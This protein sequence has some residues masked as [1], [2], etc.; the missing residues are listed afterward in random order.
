MSE[1]TLPYQPDGGRESPP[2]N[3]AMSSSARTNRDTPAGTDP[4]RTSTPSTGSY[5]EHRTAV[6]QLNDFIE[7]RSTRPGA[8]PLAAGYTMIRKLGE[9]TYGTVWL[10]EDTRAGMRVAIKFFAHGTGQQWQMLQDEVKNLASL[11]STFGIIQLKDVVPDADPPYFVMTYAE[12]GSL[13]QK[14]ENAPLSLPEAL[15]LFTQIT[16][17]LAFVHA[18]GIRHCDLKPGNVLINQHGQPLIADFGQAHLSDDAAPALGTFF[19]MSPE[20][21][22]PGLAIA[23]TSWDVYSLGALFYAMLTGQPP[24]KDAALSAELKQTVRL[25]HRLKIYRECIRALPPPTAHHRVPGM[26]RP[27]A[28]IIDRCLLLNGRERYRD[29]GAVLDALA[30]RGRQRRQRPMLIFGLVAPLLLLGLMLAAGSWAVGNAIGTARED[31]T[32][33]LL[34]NDKVMARMAAKV[35]EEQLLDGVQMIE[36]F[37]GEATNGIAPAIVTAAQRRR[38]GTL[39]PADLQPLR[40]W[41]AEKYATRRCRDYFRSVA[42]IDPDGFV[43][44]RVDQGRLPTDDEQRDLN[45]QNY[46]WRDWFNGR[47]D[48]L[49]RRGEHFPMVI[50]THICQPYAGV[51]MNVGRR[52]INVSTPIRDGA[53]T[54]V[55]L[56]VGNIDWDQTVRPWL[57]DLRRWLTE[58]G[59]GGGFPVVVND[60]GQCLTHPDRIIAL[61]PGQSAKAFYPPA[62]VASVTEP[63][64]DRAHADPVRGGEVHLAGF[65]PAR[66]KGTGQQWV[67]LVQH[68][69]AAVQRPVDALSERMTRIGL[70]I[71]AIMALLVSGIWG[72][73][74]WTLRR[75]ERLAHG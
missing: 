5:T 51:K 13:A 21:A 58:A 52:Q 2:N 18:K 38:A 19:F 56:L 25:H 54:A 22:E 36:E 62:W 7:S 68:D 24:R 16:E 32:R 34:D 43:L 50:A 14:L 57:D 8:P 69:P 70:G 33:Q 30:T 9:G 55:G 4:S 12:G 31:L 11:E 47:G 10:A 20:Q 29:A 59:S 48:Q 64:T 23:D 35:L 37:A 53:G 60:H 74:V 39:A 73:L 61:E 1:P 66:P 27:L 72:W 65:A 46:A 75:E 49:E 17:A 15:R 26:D 67:V 3:N 44:T 45:Q 41:L 63:G 28:A 6:Q 40:T 71:L 42:L